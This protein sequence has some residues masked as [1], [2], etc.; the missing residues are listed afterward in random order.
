MNFSHRLQTLTKPLRLRDSQRVYEKD[1]N[2]DRRSEIRD[3]QGT[4]R[5]E[6]ILR[7]TKNSGSSVQTWRQSLPRRI[8]YP[9]YM[10]LAE[11]LAPTAWPLCS[12]TADRTYGLSLKTTTRDEATPSSVQ[13]S[14]AYSGPG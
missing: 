1:E 11:T 10:P 13:R 12:G 9:H 8:G 6:K 4:G 3:P 2:G 5:H 7:L 14:E